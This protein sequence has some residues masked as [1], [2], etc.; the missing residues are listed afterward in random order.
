MVSCGGAAGDS[1]VSTTASK[2]AGT[3][4]TAAETEAASQLEQLP[5]DDYQGYEFHVL[6]N[7]QDDRYVDVMTEDGETGDVLNDV[8]YRRNRAVEEK[9]NIKITA[10]EDEYGNVNNMLKKEVTAGLNDYDLYFSN[11]YATSLA[12]GGYLYVIND[13]PNVNLS[14]PWWD[15][16]AL[17][18]LSVNKKTYL[19]TGDISPTSLMTSSCLVFNKTLFTNNDM[20]FPYQAAA[21]G[22][23]T[24]DMLSQYL[25]GLTSDLNG[26]GKYALGDD[27]FALSSWMCD[28]PYSLFYG[29]GGTLS[30]KDSNDIPQVEWDMDKISSIYNKMY[31][32]IVDSNSYF[33]TDPTQYETTYQCFSNGQAYFCEI[34]L[35]KIDMFLRDMKDDYGI[36]PIPK[37]DES[38]DGYYSCVNGAGG[39]VVVPNNAENPERTGMI[40][41]AMAAGAYDTITP[42]IYEVITK[43]KNVRDEESADMVNLITRNRVFDPFYI[44]L[45][46]GY[47]F[48][49]SLLKDKKKDVASYMAKK[50]SAAAKAM[51]K[52]VSAYEDLG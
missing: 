37:Y 2:D 8:V 7:N 28:S 50:E 49:Q 19:V 47:D 30:K 16:A 9:Y 45:C 25:T 20:E 21:D 40:M 38:Q 32:I 44:N 51:Q 1:S 14:N 33:V 17:E 18:G 52:I 3:E 24:L 13:L 5:A 4:T 6:L 39:Y 41:E 10:T 22:K 23:W 48:A 43:T 12:S 34:T 26:D 35:Q 15:P 29:A 27:L 46:A 31:S 36:L 42:S 11:C